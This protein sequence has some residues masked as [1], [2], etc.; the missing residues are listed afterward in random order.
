MNMK[1]MILLAL[2]AL[3]V[4]GLSLGQASYQ[5]VEYKTF[6]GYLHI[7]PSGVSSNDTLPGLSTSSWTDVQGW[8]RIPE[9][10]TSIS[11]SIYGYGDGDGAG[12]PENGTF[13]ATVYLA[14]EFG[15]AMDV[16]GVTG[17]IGQVRMS[18]DPVIGFG[19]EYAAGT[20]DTDHKWA[21]L[22]T[23]ASECWRAPVNVAGKIDG[24]GEI[25]FAP[26]GATHVKVFFTAKT[27]ITTLYAVMTGRK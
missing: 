26:L 5:P 18:H 14:N 11:I 25:N 10:W 19:S 16:C 8:Q 6:R 4:L 2:A 9:D 15:G 3:V 1:R 22:M 23:L 20:P 12:N 21:E 24:I 27:N 7:R 13:T 17:A